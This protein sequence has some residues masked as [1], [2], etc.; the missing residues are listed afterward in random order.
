MKQVC[1]LLF[2]VASMAFA[3]NNPSHL[4]NEPQIGD[5]LIINKTN[6]NGYQHIYF[7]K[8]N[9]IAKKGGIA[10]YHI[11]EG[12]HAVIKNVEI[13]QNGDTIVYLERK[14]HKKFFG[15]LNE[16]KANYTKSLENG[17]MSLLKN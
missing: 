15:C 8:L 6:A 3:S 14:N 13:N 1:Y 9:F 10:N 7:P 12:N 2:F 17:E 5:V 11:V 16:V 4:K